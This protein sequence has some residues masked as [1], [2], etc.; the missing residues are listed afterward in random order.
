MT[1]NGLL[2]V[3]KV[4]QARHKEKKFLFVDLVSGTDF[5]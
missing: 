5:R 1:H 3:T 4:T 2:T